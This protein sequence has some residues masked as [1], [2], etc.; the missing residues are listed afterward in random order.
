MKTIYSLLFTLILTMSYAQ[1][2]TPESQEPI[3]QVKKVEKLK[4]FLLQ[5]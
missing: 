3:K 2:K 5:Q 1:E 4:Q